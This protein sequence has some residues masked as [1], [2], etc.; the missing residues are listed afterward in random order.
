MPAGRTA[1]MLADRPVA[2]DDPSGWRPIELVGRGVTWACDQPGPTRNAP[3]VV[4]LH[5]WTATGSLNWAPTIATLSEGYR[6]IA[7]DHRGH[8]RGIRSVDAFTLEDCA[9]DAVALLDA[10][11][12]RTAIFVGYS[13]GGP[14][15]QLIWR[16]HPGRVA[17]LVLC[18]TSSDFTTTPDRWP[19]VRALD[20]IQRAT[21]LLPRSVR[22]RVAGPLLGGLVADPGIRDH[23]LDALHS[24]E[25]RAIH[26][27]GRAIRRFDSSR[28]IGEVDVPA[29][30]VITERDRLVPPRRQRRLAA[31]I[32]GARVIRLDG[33][34]LAAFTRPDLTARAVAA[35]CDAIAP[36]RAGGGRRRLVGRL[37]QLV[38]RRR[39]RRRDQARISPRPRT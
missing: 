2:D 5:G 26:E 31:A 19:I 13:M 23:L 38:G 18:A 17:G 16:R 14:I 6:V 32:P 3:T 15:A 8:G 21:R 11:G 9:D 24:H 4:L 20:E 39:R 12:V 7:L 37:R 28:W 22:L 34:H 33:A 30:V 1:A 25:E 29:A 36:P 35:A 27:A 10:L